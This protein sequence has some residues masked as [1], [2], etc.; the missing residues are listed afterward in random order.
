MRAVMFRRADAYPEEADYEDTGCEV[1]PSCLRCPLP[2]CK[3]VPLPSRVQ[4]RNGRVVALLKAGWSTREVAAELGYSL[5][6]VA[7]I[8]AKAKVGEWTS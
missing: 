3:Y 7:R 4:E 8:K 1:A 6:S 5:R 2:A